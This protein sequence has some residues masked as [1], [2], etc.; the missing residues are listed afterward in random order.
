M[1]HTVQ[2][3]DFID[4]KKQD[5]EVGQLGWPFSLKI[6]VYLSMPSI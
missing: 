1:K 3:F 5:Q 2:P 4:R 6:Q